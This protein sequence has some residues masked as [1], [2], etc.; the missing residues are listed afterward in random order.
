MSNS[1]RLF[2]FIVLVL[3]SCIAHAGGAWTGGLEGALK[4]FA[5]ALEM[6]YRADA[7]KERQKELLEYQNKLE[8][9]RLQRQQEEE[10]L[11]QEE[12]RLKAERDRQEKEANA[13]L[14]G[15]GFFV[16]TNGYFVTNYHVIK[17][18]KSIT[19]RIPDGRKFEGRVVRSD[20]VNDLALIKVDGRFPA[21]PITSSHL[22]KRG[23]SVATVGY[24]HADIQGVEPKVTE[25]IISSLS[26][27]SDDPRMFQISAAI[28]AGNSGGPLVTKEGNVIGVIVSKLSAVALLKQTGDMPQ[29]VNYAV[30]SN[31]LLELLTGNHL[32]NNLLRPNKK[33]FQNLEDIT[34]I[35]EKATARVVASPY[36]TPLEGGSVTRE[37]T[38]PIA[39]PTPPPASPAPPLSA[40]EMYNNGR[41]AYARKEYSEAMRWYRKAAE[42]G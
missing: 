8:N 28:Q 29:N 5:D 37:K 12:Q 33:S 9:E 20:A 25:G 7:E 32:D 41:S 4:G 15:S 2:L 36:P 6:K 14:I 1:K 19:L 3:P 21:L 34:A 18:S 42:L 10:R 26:G 27:I 16:T 24:P 31:Y 30:K 35:V 22:A 38:P 11:R 23:Q 13:V 17:N 40:A 39:L